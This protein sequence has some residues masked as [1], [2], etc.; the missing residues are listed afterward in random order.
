MTAKQIKKLAIQSFNKSYNLDTKQIKKVAPFLR[1]RELKTYIKFIKKIEN[2]K[3]INVFIPMDK[4]DKKITNKIMNIFPNK[5]I[6]YFVDPDLI[7]GIR[8]VDN[9]MVYEFNLED[10]LENLIAHIRESYD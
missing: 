4:V 5:T 7:A 10:S 1:R 6:Q 3:K 2:E 9:D 8:I